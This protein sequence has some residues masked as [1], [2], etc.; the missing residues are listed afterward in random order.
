MQER[1]EL[2]ITQLP[3]SSPSLSICWAMAKEAT[4]Q[5]VADMAI[6]EAR[7]TCR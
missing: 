5:G 1:A 6:R 4:A 7:S 3:A 2:K